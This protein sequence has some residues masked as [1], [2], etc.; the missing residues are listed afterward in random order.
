V[1]CA[2]VTI[3]LA[4]PSPRLST[5]RLRR[6]VRRFPRRALPRAARPA[7]PAPSRI[8]SSTDQEPIV[9][10]QG[11]PSSSLSIVQLAATASRAARRAVACDRLRRTLDTATTHPGFGAYEEDGG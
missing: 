10:R 9:S 4:F 6:R 7:L 1:V 5:R 2:A 3:S 8:D 11:C